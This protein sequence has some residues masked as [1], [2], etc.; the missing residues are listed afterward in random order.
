[1]DP[2]APRQGT[3]SLTRDARYRQRDS[4]ATGGLSALLAAV[5]GMGCRVEGIFAV[6]STP[7]WPEPE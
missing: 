6:H 5:D 7:G 1:M 2:L 4:S 3:C